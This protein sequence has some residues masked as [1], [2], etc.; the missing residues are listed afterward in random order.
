MIDKQIVNEKD[1]SNGVIYCEKCGEKALTYING[2]WL[3]GDCA[4][5]FFE[6]A[7]LNMR[8]FVIG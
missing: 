5:E 8:K 3:C 7:K 2:V 6:K 1:I 4:V